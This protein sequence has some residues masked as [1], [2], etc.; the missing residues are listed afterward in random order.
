VH[1][2]APPADVWVDDRLVVRS[3]RIEGRGLFAAEDIPAGTT[4]VR[5]GGHLVSSTEL[6]E[7]IAKA[8]ADP[9][10][11]YVDTTTVYA[12]AHLV[13]PAGTKVHFGNHSCDPNTWHVGAYHIAARRDIRAGDEV[14]IDYGT[15]SGAPGF[16]MICN[17]GSDLCRHEVTSDDWSRVE[18][19][20]RYGDHWVPALWERIRAATTRGVP[21]RHADAAT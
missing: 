14:T 20:A 13:M 17:C 9:D 8:D 6:A 5:L 3:S 10:T 21:A 16:S 19:Q 4:L 1:R 15:T 12:D 18:L 11:P 7:L 2:E